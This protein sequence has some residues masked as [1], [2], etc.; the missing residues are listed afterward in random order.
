MKKI[1]DFIVEKRY[2]ILSLFIVL[3]IICIFLMPKVNINHEIS[4]YLPDDSETRIGMNIM[5]DEFSSNPSSSYNL[6]FKGL[7]DSEKKK[8]YEELTKIKNVSSVDYDESDNYNKGEYTYYV[9]NVDSEADSEVSSQVYNDIKSK[10]ED[11]SIKT[12]GD[13][14]SH[15]KPVLHVWIIAVAIGFAMI[16]LIAM[17]DS[18]IHP[19]LIL[20]TV[21]LA[22][23]INKGTNIIFDSVSH[24]TNS[25]VAI[26]QMALSMDYAIMLINRFD[27]EKE[28]NDN[29]VEAM[30]EALSKSF[31]SIASSSVTTIVGLL[32]LIFMSFTIGRDLG[33]VL[34][35]G[36]LL[37]LICIL[38]CL[39]CLL[40]IFDKLIEKTKKKVFSPKLKVLG[41]F[42]YKIRFI[43][44]PTIILLFV[45]SYFLK[46][47][48]GILYTDTEMNEVAQEFTLNNQMA[49]IYKNE[50]EEKISKYCKTLKDKE[51][52]KQALCYGNTIN[53]KL[54]YN[55]LLN[56]LSD[57]GTDVDIDEYLIK[58]IYYNYYNK[59][60]NN[61]MTFEEFIKYNSAIVKSSNKP[62][63]YN[64]FWDSYYDNPQ[65]TIKVFA[66][67]H[68]PSILLRIKIFLYHFFHL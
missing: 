46:G 53:E 51:N 56:K 55:E 58:I 7:N 20:F 21:G 18:Y 29:K 42:E 9:I 13:I 48:L 25:I 57:L 62:K 35:K 10:Y 32:A 23:F 52:V 5:E 22:V 36:V 49:I 60:Q 37:S 1:T 41:K 50:D 14:A 38:F 40:L 28:K 19:F 4:E 63:E 3:T 54:K 17:C 44:I 30:K 26:L 43:S 31:S 64:M 66:S 27:Q 34:A 16:I 2:Y 45:A 65:K 12:S 59:D 24:I 67:Y 8:I 68:K 6:M 61:K 39:P 11:Y 47:N 15:N 33:F